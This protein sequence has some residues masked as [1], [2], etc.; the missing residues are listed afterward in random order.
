MVKGRSLELYFIDGKA[1]GM[2]TAEVFNWTGHVLMTPRTR[3]KE[4][5]SRPEASYTGVYILLGETVDGDAQA[6]IGET[7]ELRTRLLQHAQEKGW[8]ETA[9]L[10]TSVA[11]KLHKAHIKYLEA[12]LVELAKA[13]R[14]RQLDN[15]TDPP[16]PSLSE[17]TT[18]SMEDFLDTLQIVLP[19]IQVD[20]F[21][22][23]VRPSQLSP[24]TPSNDPVFELK[25]PKHGVKAE[26]VF[27][28]DEMIVQQG[29]V[30]RGAWSRAEHPTYTK[31]HDKLLKDGIIETDGT[32]GRFTESYAFSSPSAAAA[33]LNG[34]S[35]N[36]RKEWKLKGTR[37]TYADWEAQ[38]LEQLE[39]TKDDQRQ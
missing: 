39:K 3:L 34:R 5:L 18:A 22:N 36:G 37:L 38:Q 17:G 11:D 26:A 9:V 35:T 7:K 31:L 29:A 4:A 20:M 12:R 13:S 25:T 28:D 1:D 33:I 6:Y 19:A 10:I 21:V 27:K 2:L 23:N 15:N 30:S 8:W 32:H 24:Q 14:R 16:R